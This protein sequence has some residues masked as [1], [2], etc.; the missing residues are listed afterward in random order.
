M[1]NNILN[2]NITRE[3]IKDFIKETIETLV[4]VFILV[5]FIRS[6]IGEPRWIPSSSMEPTLQVGDNLIIEKISY[7]LSEPV[8]GDVVVFY[9][10]HHELDPSLLG[11]FSRMVGFFS[12]DEAYI[13]RVIGVPGDKIQVVPEKGVYVNGKLLEEPYKKEIFYGMC[14][15]GM[16]CG[17]FSVPQGSYYVLGDNRNDSTDSRYWGALPKKRI[18]GKAFFRFWPLNR[19]GTIND[20]KYDIENKQNPAQ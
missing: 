6:I 3:Q 20:P 18:V 12:K 15:S 17:P 14:H 16:V 10:P 9:P 13:K 2:K 19:I 11:K 5:V 7:R 8:R 4:I 1:I